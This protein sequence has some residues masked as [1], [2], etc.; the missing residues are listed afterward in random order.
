[1]NDY[2]PCIEFYLL[3]IFW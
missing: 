2:A 3:W 1:L